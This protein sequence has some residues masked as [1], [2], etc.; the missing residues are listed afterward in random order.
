MNL[1]ELTTIKDTGIPLIGILGSTRPTKDYKKKMGID[2]GYVVRQ[3]LKDRVGYVFT[4]GVGGVGIDA[5]KGVTLYCE[6]ESNTTGV[7]P[8]DKFFILIPHRYN[9]RVKNEDNLQGEKNLFSTPYDPPEMYEKLGSLSKRGSLDIV[10]AGS[11]MDERRRY[12]AEFADTAVVVN[13]GLGTLD[14]AFLALERGKRVITLPYSGGI[15]VILEHILQK[16]SSLMF[17]N[18]LEEEQIVIPEFEHSLL[19]SAHSVSELSRLLING[20]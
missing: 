18:Y 6:D 20:K 13:G 12:V 5:Y 14:E 11:S 4:G 17:K 7:L 10:R 2:V 3:H 1:K 8:D 16:D 9:I 15:S 19:E